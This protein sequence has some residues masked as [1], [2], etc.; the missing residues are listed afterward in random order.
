MLE[1]LKMEKMKGFNSIGIVLCCVLYSCQNEHLDQK[2]MQ[3]GPQN[4]VA[5][6]HRD[7]RVSQKGDSLEQY[8]I[9]LISNSIQKQGI[10]D[11]VEFLTY[12]YPSET[13]PY[14]WIKVGESTPNRFQTEFNFVCHSKSKEVKYVN[15]FTGD[16]IDVRS[17]HWYK[18]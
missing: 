7:N 2:T 16:S 10:Q 18:K 4:A 14:Y 3:S 5:V 17:N 9:E 1:C 11:D 8:F 13:D 15:V 12:R 6:H